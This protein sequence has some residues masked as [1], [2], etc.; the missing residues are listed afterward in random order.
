[1]KEVVKKNWEYVLYQTEQ[2]ELIL[3]V[4]CGSVALYDF[5]FVL[6]AQE[7]EQFKEEGSKFLDE[8]A[9]KVNYNPLAFEHRKVEIQH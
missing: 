9:A 6:D 4:V 3:S 2:S 8:L 5:D 1:M 7:K